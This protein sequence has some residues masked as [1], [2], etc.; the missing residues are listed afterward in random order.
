VVD[1]CPAGNISILFLNMPEILPAGHAST[2]YLL[3]PA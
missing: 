2:T 1:E 3:I